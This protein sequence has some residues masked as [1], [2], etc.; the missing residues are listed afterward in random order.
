MWLTQIEAAGGVDDI[1]DYKEL[2]TLTAT[3]RAVGLASADL[4]EVSRADK[5]SGKSHVHVLLKLPEMRVGPPIELFIGENEGYEE[6]ISSYMEIAHRLKESEEVRSLSNYLASVEAKVKDDG[7]NSSATGKTQMAFNLKAREECD[8][9]YIVCGTPGDREQSVYSAFGTRTGEFN[10]C[11]NLDLKAMERRTLINSVPLGSVGQI[12]AMPTLALYSFILAALQ[13]N[14]RF[15][16]TTER[17][18]IIAELKRRK[19]SRAKPLVFFLDEFPRTRH[20]GTRFENALCIMRNVFRSFG[21]AVVLSST[22][23]TARNLVVPSTQARNNG[24]CRWCMVFPSLPGVVLDG[25]FD[26]HKLL[27]KI[28]SRSRTLLLRLLSSISTRTRISMAAT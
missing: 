12:C 20:Y 23:G 21:L 18:D 11:I 27:M 2:A 22:N 25:G 24:S 7:E 6:T 28:L 16:G 8:V 10:M 26:I 14:D 5:A 3:L 17:S 15:F 4:A 13:G 9:F 19:E 1:D